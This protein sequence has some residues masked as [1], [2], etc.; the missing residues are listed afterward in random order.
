MRPFDLDVHAARL[1]PHLAVLKPPGDG[2]FPV[3]L[4]MHGCG[5][6]QPM[7]LR[8]ARTAV[9]AGFAAEVVDSL[10]PRGIGRR[11]AQFTVC[12][13]LQ[14]RGAE[15]AIDLLAMLHWLEAQSWA[16]AG[17]VVAAGWSHGAWSI[18]EAM[19]ESGP[20]ARADLLGAVRTVVLVYP[21]A[22]P[23]ART[24]SSGWGDNR[25]KVRA[26]L[27]GRDAVVGWR[28]AKRA[29]DRLA[30]DG[31]DVRVLILPDATHCFDDDKADDPRTLYSAALEA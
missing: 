16:D 21:Y 22:G 13:L 18:M 28:A 17:R 3:A 15:R 14:L 6:I 29:L 4:Q 9:E 24:F 23:P 10:A 30:A 25:P 7:Q 11:A 8:Y 2:P 26:L 12:T 5:G 19:A 20:A 1:A 31:L 27:G